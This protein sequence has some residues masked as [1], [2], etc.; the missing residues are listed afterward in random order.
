M[1]GLGGLAQVALAGTLCALLIW[2]AASDMQ[3]YVIPNRICLSL[4]LLYPGYAISL[5]PAEIGVAAAIAASVFVI[6][7]GLFSFGIMGGGDVKL[8]AAMSLWA[9]GAYFPS[10]VVLTAAA[11]GMLALWWSPLLRFF[12]PSIALAKAANGRP[13]VPYG[14]AIAVGGVFVAI[15]LY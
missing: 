6:G 2:A 1:S 12:F 14:A 13:A 11:G 10:F 5:T 7:A 3:R 15:N 9:G 8:L 4:L